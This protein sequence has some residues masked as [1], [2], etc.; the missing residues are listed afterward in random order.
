MKKRLHSLL[1]AMMLLMIALGSAQAQNGKFDVRFALKTMDCVNQK[2][3]ILVQVR[4]TD[5]SSTFLMGDAN[6]R[7]DYNTTQIKNPQIVV[8]ENFSSIA[9]SS[10]SNYNP[11]TKTGTSE[12]ASKG[13]MSLNVTY[14]GSNNGAKQV[15]VDWMTV[16]CVQFD[17]VSTASCFELVWHTNTQF[18]ITGMSEVVVTNP[19]TFEYDLKNVPAG[20][21]YGN[22][23][24]CPG[25]VCN[26]VLGVND[27]NSTLQGRSVTGQLLT[28]DVG[29]NLVAST[30]PLS[31]PQNGTIT[32]SPNGSYIYTPQPGFVGTDM[33]VYRVCNSVT[34][35]CSNATLTVRVTPS[36]AIV[37]GVN[38]AP[39]AMNDVAQTL[40]DTPVSSTV[41]GNDYDPEGTQLSVR[42]TPL[43]N[44]LNGTVV[45]NANGT[46]TYTP[47][48]GF[49][50]TDRFK[51]EVCDAGTP[52]KCDT[53]WVYI[54]VNPDINGPANNRPTAQDDMYAG[55]TGNP[56]TGSVHRNDSDP[57]GNTLTFSG[58]ILQPSNGTITFNSNGT[59][60]YTPNS[61]FTG[62]DRFTY[63][64]CD[65][66]SPSLCDTATVYLLVYP[67]SSQPPTIPPTTS[68][69]TT[70]GTP[71][72]V[73]VNIT[74]PDINDIHTASLCNTP[75]SVGGTASLSVSNSSNP[76]Q[77][78]ITY[79]P[80]ASFVGRDTVCVRLCDNTGT[81]S[82]QKIPVVV[83]DSPRPPTL[84]PTVVQA[85]QGVTTTVCYAVSDNL[86][87]SHTASFCSIP[88]SGTATVSV[89]ASGQVC[90]TYSPNAGFAGTENLCVRVCDQT[91][92]CTNVQ[93]PVTVAQQP[94][95]PTLTVSTPLS[96]NEDAG[97]QIF[98]LPIT[99]PNAGDTH[100]A[101]LCSTPVNGTATVSVNNATRQVCVSYT[102]NS[103]FSGVETLCIRTCDQ[104]GLCSNTTV[105]ITVNPVA[106][107]PVVT[108][109][110]FVTTGDGP[111]KTVCM[112]ISDADP[113]DVHTAQLCGTPSNGTATTSVVNG[114]VCV[115]YRP[116]A[117]FSG[118]DNVCVTVCDSYGRCVNSTIPIT[119]T[120]VQHPPSIAPL[121]PTPIPRDQ[122]RVFC[123]RI[124]DP[125][126]GDTHTST[127]CQQP[128][129]GV[130]VTSVNN[131]TK[132]VCVTYVPNTGYLGPDVICVRV[133]DQA[134]N[135]VSTNINVL[136]TNNN[137]P[138]SVPVTS[139]T[140]IEDATTPQTACVT[141]SDL[142]VTD[143][144]TATLCGPPRNGTAS[145]LVNNATR[146]LCVSYTP[147]A[148]F[149][150]RD[151]VCVNI[152]DAA[153]NCVIAY[154][155]PVVVSPVNDPPQITM[156]LSVPPVTG[157]S[158]RYCFPISDPDAGD[159]HT[160]TACA[161]T[162]RNGQMITQIN[163]QTKEVCVTYYPNPGYS[164]TD[165]ICVN[166]CDASGL[167][168]TRSL[169]I[170]VVSQNRPPVA[171]SDI[172][173]TTKN[174]PVSGTVLT[175]DYDP[176]AG[177][178]LTFSLV[179][180]P[181]YGSLILNPNGQYV[182]T[183]NNNIVGSDVFSYRVCD[184][185]TPQLCDIATV[186]IRI[187]DS[188]TPPIGSTNLPPTVINDAVTVLPNTP[189]VIHVKSNDFDF[190][191]TLGNPTIKTNP[192]HGTVSV[193]L[194]GTVRYIPNT[195][196]VGNDSFKYYVCDNGTP[197]KCDTATVSIDVAMPSQVTGPTNNPPVAGNDVNTTPRNTSVSGTV[198]SNDFDPNVGQTL[199][200]NLM[201]IPA[202]GTVVFNPNGTYTYTPAQGFV[203]TDVFSY[204]VCDNGV[205]QLCNTASVMIQVTDPNQTTTINLKPIAIDDNPVTLAGNPITFDVRI[206]DFDPNGTPLGLPVRIS[207]PSNGTVVQNPNGTFTYT[208][209]AGFTGND[210][211]RYTVCDNG[212]PSLCETATVTIQVV[213]NNN[214]INPAI[215][216][217]PIPSDDIAIVIKG[218]PYSNTVSTNDYDP[219]VGQTLTYSI[220]TNPTQGTV[221]LNT[222]GTYIYTPTN[223]NF[224]G[225]DSFT[226]RACDNGTP[227]LC[228]NAT[229]RVIV[230]ERS[231]TSPTVTIPQGQ[232]FVAPE[233]GGPKTFCFSITDPDVGQTFTS[234]LCA[235][236]QNGTATTQIVGGQVCVTYTPNPNFSGTEALCLRVC[237]SQNGCTNIQIPIT[238][239]QTPDPPVVPVSVMTL[240]ANSSRTVCYPI[241]D[242]DGP[243]DVHTIS[244]CASP[245]L[246]SVSGTV[247]NVTHQMCITYTPIAGRSGTDEICVNV[248]D[249]N[250]MC[251]QVRIPVTV[252]A[253]NGK[254]IAIADINNTTK[255]SPV[256]GN[257]LSNDIDPDNNPLTTVIVTQAS[258]GLVVLNSNG[259]YI[260]YPNPNFVGTDTF[261]YRVCDNASTALCDET[262]VTVTVIEP[263]TP[264]T[265]RPPVA[266]PDNP[267]GYAG[268]PIVINVRANDYDPEGGVLGMPS[269]VTNPSNGTVIVN[270]DG[271]IRYVPNSG[272]S[273]S[274]SFVYR[275]CDN[276]TP[277]QC[278]N[279]TAYVTV[280]PSSTPPVVPVNNPPVAQ[281]DQ[282]SGQIGSTINGSV[283]TNDYDL[284][285]GQTLIYSVLSL[286]TGGT[287]S[288][289][290]NGTFSFIPNANF[291]GSTSFQYKVCDNGLP[292]QCSIATATINVQGTNPPIGNR[293]PI[294]SVDMPSTNQGTAIN[295]NV[296][297]N[298]YDPD[299]GQILGLPS[300]VTNPS[301]GTVSINP[302]GT[303][304]Y[305]PNAGFTG[306]DTFTYRVC[307]NGV[308]QACTTSSVAVTV[309]ATNGGGNVINRPPVA[310][311][312][313]G[314]VV[315]GSS[316]TASVATNDYD[317]DAG[318]TLSYAMVVQ[319]SNGT[320]VFNSN[321]TYTYTPQTGFVGTDYFYYR[322]CD[323]AIPS[324]CSI[325]QVAINVL[326][327]G[328]G[329]VNLPPVATPDVVVTPAG[330]AV[331]IVAKAN[332]YDPY[333]GILGNPV[334][335]TDPMHGTVTTNAN[336]TFTYVPNANFVGV[337]VFT[338]QVC[339]SGTPSLCAST[340][341]T[342]NVTAPNVSPVVVV[343]DPP[344]AIDDA[345][346]GFKNTIINGVVALNDY[347]P[348]VGQTLSYTLLTGPSSGSVVLNSSGSYIY[349]PNN[350]YVGPDRFTYRVCDN[351]TPSLCAVATVYLTIAESLCTTLDLKVL[352]EGPMDASTGLMKTI[353]N[354]R[355]L[356]PGQVPIGEFAVATP[357]GQPFNTAPWNYTG[358]ESV[359]SYPATVV[360]WVLVTL[361]SSTTV[362]SKT[363]QAA[364]LLHNDGR[365]TFVNSCFTIP[366]GAYYVLVEHRNHM[367]VMSS[368]PVSVSNSKIMYD[369]TTS[370]T[371]EL[372]NPPSFGSKP[373]TLAGQSRFVMY[374]GDGRKETQSNNFDINFNDSSLWKLTSGIFD[375]YQQADF[376]LDADVNFSDSVLW[377]LNN[378]KYSGV[379]H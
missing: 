151:T 289:N 307:D 61:N 256:A 282:V 204:R 138:P 357:A 374:A 41:L 295:I 280:L 293:P 247:N 62:S 257:V 94:V 179:T 375:R 36:P 246:G 134:G 341:V 53:A 367:G 5:A 229:V 4:A 263:T 276:G 219:N 28:N 210:S 248:C 172:N 189:T 80:T 328:G 368:T 21:Y 366:S 136:V 77:L 100:T 233:D 27:I 121:N 86:G 206:N 379:A 35:V 14:S 258:N 208:P 227:Q 123:T 132:E 111:A 72:T 324:L 218:Q 232:T 322:V 153:N 161:G 320:L 115:T 7:F 63:R 128:S 329:S 82:T 195:G 319:P 64:A 275:V 127:I 292:S 50:G 223:P 225:N 23:S 124:N 241:N 113:G 58:P 150:G 228:T 70:Q 251:T 346:N 373:M 19:S 78:C 283:A 291:V 129:N 108:L 316:L 110:P 146:Q 130:A 317:L 272:F 182:Y 51:Y 196:F 186:T 315:S 116:N 261:R 345:K 301:N 273:G 158:S 47:Q 188:T 277:Q 114:Q 37:P 98:C 253:V 369:F 278:S 194:D 353:L 177:Q 323:S 144:H 13:T 164:G 91:G 157:P 168:T 119:V 198:A 255:N 359:S 230:V 2:A 167:C 306:V 284:D 267:I 155:V 337:D 254:P 8:Q 349:T 68:I 107:P 141:I 24:V 32:I 11:Q 358:T 187:Q 250:G 99:D 112:S 52:Q 340:T 356:L 6:F 55:I 297:Q 173:I 344:V 199:V 125:D 178:L 176:D 215:N 231:N 249:Q 236:P 310:V 169:M 299:A 92:L 31:G 224:T 33:V 203:G 312:D 350:N 95:A 181:I 120:P 376:N 209:N 242:P 73:C 305:L 240:P 102:P 279:A 105:S 252:T 238:V 26:P 264:P 103:N 193:N 365:I 265:N 163:N 244:L 304:R 205:P 83:S 259:T 93:I 149:S 222:N 20:G 212:T 166:V 42:T 117:T 29:L 15:G 74:D 17:I 361:R 81:C 371:F 109:V 88:T 377:K 274:D 214:G 147:T 185:G 18:P 57:N 285:A 311:A 281:N 140:T 270:P 191:G 104:T 321:G 71:R 333:S 44:P 334:K 142:D 175:G 343:N 12:G 145:V 287:L 271:T 308:P 286:P 16:S 348:N 180:N 237:D 90:V 269:I 262:T 370:Q 160:V 171:V 131:I 220:V 84:T 364:G 45:L 65:N 1:S 184:N 336:G 76:H 25:S 245:T 87:D 133:C 211:F 226:Y 201:Q 46:Y 363:F 239:S 378:G 79:T 59:F 60:T 118:T 174:T 156:P 296:L 303:I 54:Y 290:A 260:Y 10:N 355:G 143:S 137:N 154:K 165:E 362:A 200:Y 183:P 39:I 192:L 235:S 202:Y 106:D 327:S 300:I 67:T 309:N 352:L 159:V 66:G 38:S 217:A 85:P 234:S 213:P 122:L 48:S 243:T 3:T 96:M 339:D 135:C 330:T 101:S 332:D 97:P 139:I 9:P 162:P 354:Q 216:L 288:F 325:A 207:N 326:A 360:D 190:D 197:S 56:I 318:Q 342:I 298:D 266:N 221:T 148:N 313:A 294:A 126:A 314:S 351:G 89:N 34:N 335:L 170:N 49:T 302:D 372:S 40:T 30:T 22:M 43:V 75:V 331:T 338:Y 268:S 347:D 69:S 152:C